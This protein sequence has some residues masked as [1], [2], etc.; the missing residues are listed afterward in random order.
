M[1]MAP[2]TFRD[3]MNDGARQVASL[4]ADL[5]ERGGV[6]EVLVLNAR[7]L[8]SDWRSH[9]WYGLPGA[10]D[11]RAAMSKTFPDRGYDRTIEHVLQARAGAGADGDAGI[12]L[13]LR[14]DVADRFRM[15]ARLLD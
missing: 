13:E 7:R 11:L 9:G 8:L 5:I 3:D 15:L 1:L 12:P 4:A 2:R 14:S 10:D 6:D